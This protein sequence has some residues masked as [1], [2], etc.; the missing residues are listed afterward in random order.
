MAAEVTERGDVRPDGR[1]GRV[2][3]DEDE[4]DGAHGISIFRV[5]SI[6]ETALDPVAKCGKCVD[7]EVEVAQASV[8]R[9]VRRLERGAVLCAA[10]C[11]SIGA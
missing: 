2:P 1:R 7:G 6:E 5:E 8:G 9:L 4:R 10:R 11:R 3:D